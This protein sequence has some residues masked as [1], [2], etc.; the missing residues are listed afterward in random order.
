M[1]SIKEL[2]NTI[3]LNQE[4]QSKFDLTD[5]FRLRDFKLNAKNGLYKDLGS[6]S[7][8]LR[9]LFRYQEEAE[10][11]F[12]EKYKDRTTGVMRFKNVDYDKTVRKLKRI[13]LFDEKIESINGN[14]IIKYNAYNAF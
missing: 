4:K 12:V 5:P 9:R 2:I 13:H 7:K 10:E 1:D 11:N 6:A 3:N 14:K 8:D